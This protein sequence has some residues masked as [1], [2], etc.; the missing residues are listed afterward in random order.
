MFLSVLFYFGLVDIYI[1][2]KVIIVHTDMR[3]WTLDGGRR[4]HVFDY[5]FLSCASSVSQNKYYMA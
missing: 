5:W 3:R 1:V 2:Y 4:P